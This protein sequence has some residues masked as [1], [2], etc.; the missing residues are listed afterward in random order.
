M[1]LVVIGCTKLQL[2]TKLT[3]GHTCEHTT[4]FTCSKSFADWYFRLRA[5]VLDCAPL[6]IDQLSSAD[7]TIKEMILIIL[8]N[9]SVGFR[10][11]VLTSGK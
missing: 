6:L 5:A 4:P 9:L 8:Y 2:S 1:L 11:K 7:E 10:S 3:V